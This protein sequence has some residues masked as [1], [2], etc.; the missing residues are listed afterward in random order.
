ML[1]WQDTAEGTRSRIKHSGGEQVFQQQPLGRA[2]SWERA[3]GS[4]SLV[5]GLSDINLALEIGPA[6]KI[7]AT[8]I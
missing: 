8:E 7:Y 5:C 3:V 4:S 6:G 2:G 1:E